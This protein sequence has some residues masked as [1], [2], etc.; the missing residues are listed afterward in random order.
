MTARH[1]IEQLRAFIAYDPETGIFT[2]VKARARVHVGKVL[3]L[4]DKSGY[5]H[6]VLNQVHYYAHRLA[7]LFMTGDWPEDYVDHINGVKADN[8][9]ANLRAATNG[10]NQQNRKLRSDSVSGLKGVSRRTSTSWAARI[11]GGH[12][13]CFP[14]PEEAHAAYMKAAREQYGEFARAA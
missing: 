9:W 7:W 1:S 10:Q 2:A 14:T 4:K 6:I 5:L 13:G 8:R 11:A 3:G 12:L